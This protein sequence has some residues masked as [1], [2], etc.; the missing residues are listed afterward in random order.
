MAGGDVDERDLAALVVARVGSVEETGDVWQPYRLSDVAGAPVVAVTA[1]LMELQASGRSAATQRSY[2]MDLLR[3]FRFLW[4]VEVPWGRATR[5]EA[6]DFCR[7]L[8]LCDKPAPGGRVASVAAGAGGVRNPVTGKPTLARTYAP[9]T[10]AHCETVVRGFYTFHQEAGSGPMVNPF[11]LVA[12]RREGRA[13]A[14]HNPMEPWRQERSGRYR[15]R[16]AQRIPRCIP[17]ERFSQ[18]FAELGSHRDRALVSLWVSTGAR[19]A[20]LLGARCGDIDAGQ[21][22]VTVV[23]KGSR[24]VQQLPAS[25]DAFVWVRLYQCTLD[26]STRV[27]RDD[28]LWWTLR[29]PVRPLT[30]PAARAMFTRANQA[31]GANWS[32]HDLRHTAAHRMARDPQL[33]LSD[34][35]WVLGH[36]HLSTTQL[37]L[38]PIPSEV[39]AGVL[40]HHRRVPHSPPPSPAQDC[41]GAGEYRAESLDTLFS[42]RSS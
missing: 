36:A 21:Q 13:H 35:Q 15:P 19:A 12:Q 41:A 7:W 29:R 23:R 30:Y 32:L 5:V 9:A 4:A 18:L 37:Y 25:P 34:V 28:P 33:P 22:L 14:H 27:G 31:L 24:A 3:W 42:R 10:R 39:I 40:A 26:A 11:P 38:T 16:L 6:R 20:E 2:A 1:F 17:D 8:A